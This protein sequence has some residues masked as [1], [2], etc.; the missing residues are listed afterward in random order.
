MI[1][2]E[3]PALTHFRGRAM[4]ISM[5]VG[6]MA[7]VLGV[8][9]ADRRAVVLTTDIGVETDDQW[10]LAHL[11]LSP[12]FELK[13]VVTTHAP[14]LADPAAETSASYARELIAKL[15]AKVRPIVL[16]GSSKALTDPTKP[17]PNPGVDFLIE[18]AKGRSADNRLTVVVIGAATDVA[19]ALLTDQTWADRVA[20]VAMAFDGYPRGGDPWNVK[21]DPIAWRIL[22]DSRAPI[23]VGDTS[24]TRQALRMT[25]DRAHT[26]LAQL[27]DPAKA[28]LASFDLW[29][30]RNAK[31][32]EAQTG[33]P[34]VWP[35]WDE[36]TVAYLLGMART[37]TRPR[38]RMRDD[39]TFDLDHPRGTIEWVTAI[40]DG[41]LWTDLVD[42]I[43]AGGN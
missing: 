18:Q 8:M 41:R 7:A 10:A 24:V 34:I 32:A 30:G 40:D 11:A 39:L 28:L 38:P 29:I 43:K 19:S 33:S 17:H 13:G 15:P 9:P 37:E 21:N 16:A 25:P 14:N 23:V 26:L 12:E 31:L 4:N 6:V 5:A 2:N 42:R 35:I 3:M 1:E 22:L 20:I 27:P 36:V